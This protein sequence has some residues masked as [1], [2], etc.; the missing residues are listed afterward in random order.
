MKSLDVWDCKSVKI[1]VHGN[2]YQFWIGGRCNFDFFL[3]FQAELNCL[4]RLAVQ[5]QQEDSKFEPLEVDAS[6]ALDIFK[7][8]R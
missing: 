7:Y 1:Q 8:N 5:L 3:S 4:S 2:S 6:V